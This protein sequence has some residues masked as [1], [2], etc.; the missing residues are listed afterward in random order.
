MNPVYFETH[1]QR[2][3]FW[4]DWPEA[5]AIITACATTGEVWSAEKNIAADKKLAAELQKQTHWMRRLTGYSPSTHHAEPGWAV[6]I[7]FPT[8]CEI[9][10]QFAQDAIYYVTA[11]TLAVSYC[12]ARRGLV[13]IGRF[14]ARVH[15]VP[16]EPP[17]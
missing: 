13:E 14:R 17:G 7:D 1:F 2:C 4:N 12:D 8:A 10:R 9:G 16:N 15:L 6:E 5:F 11:D 3:E